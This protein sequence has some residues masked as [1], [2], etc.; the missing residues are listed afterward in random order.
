MEIENLKIQSE[1]VK[2]G[3]KRENI[4]VFKLESTP[5]IVIETF[6]FFY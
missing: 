3:V 5:E 2:K 1:E 6:P 4:D